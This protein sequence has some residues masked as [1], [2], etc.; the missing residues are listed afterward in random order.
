M[1]EIIVRW[2]DHKKMNDTGI[3]IESKEGNMYQL[4]TLDCLKLNTKNMAKSL[5]D[6][7]QDYQEKGYD[8]IFK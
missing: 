4:F 8:I 5:V 2:E 6:T 1:K 3:I 7:L